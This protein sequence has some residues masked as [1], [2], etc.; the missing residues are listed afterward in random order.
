M[1]KLILFILLAIFLTNYGYSQFNLFI[2][3]NPVPQNP[4]RDGDTVSV[5]V[6]NDIN[7]KV[8]AI[9]LNGDTIKNADYFWSFGDGISN[10]TISP[11]IIHSYSNGGCYFVV[12]KVIDSKNAIKY[13]RI[14]VRVAYTPDR[15]G[16]K[17][18]AAGKSI[19]K[20]DSVELT[21]FA[22]PR[23]GEY[24]FANQFKKKESFPIKPGT[25]KTSVLLLE[26]FQVNQ[27]LETK[28]QL[29]SICLNLEHSNIK[30][31]EIK[32]TCPNNQSVLL[33]KQGGPDITFAGE[34]VTTDNATTVIAGKTY[35]YCFNSNPT[36]KKSMSQV[37]KDE[38]T[39]S[40][41]DNSNIRHNAISY[42]PANDYATSEPL[43]QLIG[44]PL[45]GE[46]TLTINDI[47]KANDNGSFANW[48]IKIDP[49]LY[50]TAW[51][52]KN[53]YTAV[54]TSWRG[55]GTKK[56]VV[57]LLNQELKV[58]AKGKPIKYGLTDYD[59]RVFDNWG[60]P[61]DTTLSVKV[62]PP[63]IEATP[64]TAE[65][66]SKIS[67]NA[68]V[69]WGALYSWDF[70]NGTEDGNLKTIERLYEDRDGFEKD[71]RD[72][73]VKLTAKSPTGCTDT[74]SLH[75]IITIPPYTY[76]EYNAFTPNGSSQYSFK[77]GEKFSK[78]LK[79]GFVKIYNRWGTLVKSLEF[80]Y[81]MSAA[82]KET[83]NMGWDGKIR[84]SDRDADAGIYF[85][86]VEALDVNGITHKE[87]GFLYLFR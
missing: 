13:I 80:D 70:G 65:I 22:K 69:D 66:D 36:I 59:F 39:Y 51:K 77:L 12:I 60:Y 53:T 21:G 29:K 38:Y 73:L 43:D 45:L 49:N 82:D 57:T 9:Y 18:S 46:W 79:T 85:Y 28:D 68:N 33:K 40:Y 4:T 72:Y 23:T 19:C 37:A 1:K 11:E 74:A 7:F 31:L 50:K 47:G 6:N 81:K 44:C 35:N 30:N 20:G 25:E 61:H 8:T 62:A 56:S 10:S 34:P 87:K 63:V 26:S 86:Y 83:F 71:K 42:L 41:T 3:T 78:P 15:T 67:F 24:V 14:P 84:N 75:V 58:V 76:Q 32:L 5:K 55:Q 52:I 2:K 48:E 54:D 17:T 64:P 27:K 16:T